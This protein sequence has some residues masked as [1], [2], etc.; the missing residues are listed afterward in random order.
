MR[1]NAGW[2][3]LHEACNY[4]HV[5]VVELLLKYGADVNDPGG[6][7]CSNITPLHDAVD[8]GCL[9]VP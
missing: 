5:E 2:T 3:P 4:G 8:A 7:S 1:D 9:E 6:K